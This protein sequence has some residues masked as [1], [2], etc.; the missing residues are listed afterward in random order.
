LLNDE[1][2]ASA[3][4]DVVA[5]AVRATE[6]RDGVQHLREPEPLPEMAVLYVKGVRA[7]T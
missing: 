6:L 2:G 5:G 7:V 3:V 1:A 4:V